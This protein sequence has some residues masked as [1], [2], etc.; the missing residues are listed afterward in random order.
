MLNSHISEMPR[1]MP[2]M[3]DC[4]PALRIALY[5]TIVCRH[6]AKC[7]AYPGVRKIR[8]DEVDLIL[9][10]SKVYGKSG[11]MFTVPR[12]SHIFFG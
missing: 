6:I 12:N 8:A 11:L 10:K 2:D 3:R 9:P 1:L 4:L 7:L 5:E